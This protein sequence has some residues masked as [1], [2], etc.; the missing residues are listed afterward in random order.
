MNGCL[1]KCSKLIT[2]AHLNLRVLSQE[3]INPH[4][5]LLFHHDYRDLS[6]YDGFERPDEFS[7]DCPSD[8]LSTL[9]DSGQLQPTLLGS[10]CYARE[11][12]HNTVKY[13]SRNLNSGMTQQE[14]LLL[15][16]QAQEF[17]RLP[18]RIHDGILIR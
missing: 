6:L 5:I 2:V 15:T 11:L 14:M 16:C 13:L 17:T 10:L 1:E 18:A 8:L 7:Q 9:Q 4:K 3:L 12:C